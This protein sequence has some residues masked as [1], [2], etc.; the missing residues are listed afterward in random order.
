VLVCGDFAL[1]SF[2]VIKATDFINPSSRVLKD[3]IVEL[4]DALGSRAID[5]ARRLRPVEFTY[6]AGVEGGDRPRHLGMIAEEVAE[7]APQLVVGLG[8]PAD[9]QALSPMGLATLALGA[10]SD[11]AD[12][13]ADLRRRLEALESA[14]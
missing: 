7:V 10:A 11:N 2:G 8:G 14:A 4:R 12:D 3:N 1:N 9:R 13:I 6:K 5:T